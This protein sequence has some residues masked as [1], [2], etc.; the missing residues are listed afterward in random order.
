MLRFS[1]L[2]L[3]SFGVAGEGR[4]PEVLPGDIFVV[5]LSS[6]SPARDYSD[7]PILEKGEPSTKGAGT[8]SP[9]TMVAGRDDTTSQWLD[10]GNQS[11]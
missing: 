5:P 11:P 2:P 3:T 9:A 4:Q 10:A 1:F 7:E 8:S 6:A